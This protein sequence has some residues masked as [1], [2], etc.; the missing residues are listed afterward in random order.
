M[1]IHL[2]QAL[3]IPSQM[4]GSSEPIVIHSPY[5]AGSNHL[6]L[7]KVLSAVLI[8][9]LCI[10]C[11][12]RQ[13]MRAEHVRDSIAAKRK[14]EFQQWD[15]IRRERDSI[16]AARYHGKGESPFK[17]KPKVRLAP[18][19]A[20]FV[21]RQQNRTRNKTTYNSL[22]DI[23]SEAQ[24]VRSQAYDILNDAESIGCSDAADAAQVAMSR[25]NDCSDSG[26]YGDAESYL[27]EAQSQLADAESYLENCHGSR[28]SGDEDEYEE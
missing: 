2:I 6:E 1:R 10:A 26:N 13:R 11:E 4:M 19:F 27:E 12:T 22:E 14:L 5:I 18:G 8:S 25:S 3:T 23:W 7:M 15:Q 17:S 16:L 21:E 24:G 9:V 20:D 28:S